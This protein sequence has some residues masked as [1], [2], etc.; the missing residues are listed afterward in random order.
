MAGRGRVLSPAD[1]LVDAVEA[2][3]AAAIVAQDPAYAQCV[4]RLAAHDPTQLRVVLGSVVRSLLETLHPAGL[5]GADVGEV[6]SRC[7][8][9]AAPWTDVEP[10]ALVV[11]LT[12]SLGLLDAEDQPVTLAPSHIARHAPLL[13]ADLLGVSGQHLSPVLVAALA[14]VERAETVEMP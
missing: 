8:R 1:T 10:A 7:V 6:L 3:V 13:I 12:G 2:A 9:S 11:V 4:E 14:E 5:S